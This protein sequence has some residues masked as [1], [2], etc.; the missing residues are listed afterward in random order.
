MPRTIPTLVLAL[1]IAPAAHSQRPISPQELG[2]PAVK[3]DSVPASIAEAEAQGRGRPLKTT[4][5][6]LPLTTFSPEVGT[7]ERR[8]V[9]AGHARY[10]RSGE[11]SV[12]PFDHYSAV[13]NAG[14]GKLA[15]GLV[16]A[17]SAAAQHLEIEA[18]RLDR[19]ATPYLFDAARVFPNMYAG[20]FHLPSTGRWMLVGTAGDAWGCFVF[21]VS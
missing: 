20:N 19:P 21:E 1:L 5:D 3:A 4:S 2:R 12:G 14:Y 9:E 10:A 15:W 6:S 16:R 13:W 18:V 17:S 7:A 11:F 8:C